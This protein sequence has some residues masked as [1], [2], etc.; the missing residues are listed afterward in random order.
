MPPGSYNSAMESTSRKTADTR[1]S[2]VPDADVVVIGRGPVGAAAALAVARTGLK[3]VC[4]GPREPEAGGGLAI[5]GGSAAEARLAADIAGWDPRV[6]AL[7][8]ATR[9]LLER[10]HVWDAL[11]A[12]RIAPV[13]D[14]RIEPGAAGSDPSSAQLHF[15]AYEAQVDALAWIVEGRNLAQTLARAMTFSGIQRVDGSLAGIDP[16]PAGHA[17]VRLDNGRVLRARLVVAADGAQSA[18]RTALAID[19][20]ESAYAQQAVVA[21][22]EC[23]LPHQDCAYQWFDGPGVLALLPLP[24]DRCSMVWSAPLPLAAELMALDA[25]ALAQRVTAASAAR[26]GRLTTITAAQSFPLRRLDVASMIGSRTVL[27]G[28]AAHVIHPLAGQGMNLGFGDVAAL[29]DILVA[30]E[31]FRDV[32]DALLLRRYERSRREAVLRMTLACDGL[33]RLF[34]PDTVRK[35][36]PFGLPLPHVRDLGWRVVAGSGWLRRQL[37]RA[38]VQ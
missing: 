25:L 28:D 4:A 16:S 33:Q 2:V 17:L 29:A 3:V 6:F 13:Y 31:P 10:L 11:D 30:R 8:P 35:M 27:V 14:M 37:I 38:A 26:L 21:N 19:V 15:S 36:G 7:S 12:A 32:G 24:G 22:F 5:P 34:D 18:T 1:A 9:L 23:S 20:R